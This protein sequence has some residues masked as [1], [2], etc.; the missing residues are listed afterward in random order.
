MTMLEELWETIDNTIDSIDAN[1]ILE[2]KLKNITFYIA[3]IFFLLFI[4]WFYGRNLTSVFVVLMIVLFRWKKKRDD[5]KYVRNIICFCVCL[6]L[7]QY[8][9]NQSD[10]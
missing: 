7:V 6:I 1:E 5:E 10:I 2:P 4:R 9:N 8:F 3:I